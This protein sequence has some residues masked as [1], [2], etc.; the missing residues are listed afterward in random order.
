MNGFDIRRTWAQVSDYVSA[1]R[2]ASDANT[3]ALGFIR[4]STFDRYA[5]QGKLLVAV[6][7]NAD[8]AG[9][10]LFDYSFPRAVVLQ[11]FCDPKFRRNGVARALVEDLKKTLSKDGFLSIRASV[12]DDLVESN[13]FWGEAGFHVGRKRA[14]GV[15]TGRVILQRVH[16]LDSPQL[17]ARS[18]LALRPDNPLGLGVAG[19]AA[20]P[21][22][23]IDLN[24]VFDIAHARARAADAERLLH[25]SHSGEC[26]VLIST[27]MGVELQRHA[28]DAR[29][30]PMLRLLGSIPRIPAPK[31]DVT[32]PLA[33]KIAK[34]I[35][36]EKEFPDGLSANDRSDV[37]HLLTAMSCGATA[38][39]TRDQRILD[40]SGCLES[41][42]GLRV[43]APERLWDFTSPDVHQSV[44]AGVPGFMEICAVSEASSECVELLSKCGVSA[45]DVA[46][47]W[48]NR[49]SDLGAVGVRFGGRLHALAVHGPFDPAIRVSTLRLAVDET[50]SVAP[51]ASRL[52]LRQACATASE[53]DVGQVR[54]EILSGQPLLKGVAFEMG[55]RS[56]SPGQMTKGVL[57]RALTPFNWSETVRH[58]RDTYGV[59]LPSGAP[60]WGG[61]GQL[62][63]VL[64][65]DGE[66]RHVPI[67]ELET[68]LSPALVCLEGRPG[69]VAPI[70]PR[71]SDALLGGSKQLS[72]APKVEASTHG[73]R[74]FLSAPR[75]LG[76]FVRGGL[77]FFYQSET[78]GAQ[79]IIAVAR[80]VDAYLIRGDQVGEESLRRS[81]L[82]VGSLPDIGTSKDKAACL[83]DNLI[84]LPKPVSL[85]ALRRIGYQSARLTSAGRLKSEQTLEVLKQGFADV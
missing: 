29:N 45:V 69:I 12:A 19:I 20:S 2:A 40:A 17:F 67:L 68:L 5:R 60:P 72:L 23:L 64:C 14:G 59:T 56:S 21:V 76:L 71:F 7:D 81:V 47:K 24:V 53:S 75:L 62:L 11:V 82:N 18:G 16:E 83:F 79:A 77:I 66:R 54:L 44:E 33:S 70:K 43:L 57:G 65:A 49:A 35:F 6:A 80:I 1:A 27:E 61:T 41:D 15:T 30:D 28:R 26:R 50:S 36:P 3:N 22:Y 46:T 42:H 8:Y 13:K 38:F 25:A 9:H 32:L 48:C 74:L 78:K 10:L 31:D 84:F 63:E 55:F 34:V 52:L 58:V 37:R 85:A 4:S 39:I 51:A 73:E